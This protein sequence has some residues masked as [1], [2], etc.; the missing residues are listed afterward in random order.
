MTKQPSL[1]ALS[2]RY[3]IDLSKIP[4]H[5]AI[6]MDGNGRWAKKRRLP[7]IMGHRKGADRVR[8]IV[9]ACGELGVKNLTL[10]AFSEENWQRPKHE[11]S[12]IMTLINTY[13]RKEK[14]ELRQNKVKLQSIGSIEKLP[15]SCQ[16]MLAEVEDYLADGSGLTL[17]L[18]LSYGGRADLARTFRRLARKVLDNQLSPDDI[19]EQLLSVNIDEGKLDDVDLMIRTS[20]EIRI[21]NFLLWHLAYAELYFTKTQWPDFGIENLYEALREFQSRHRRFGAVV[22]DEGEVVDTKLSPLDDSL[23]LSNEL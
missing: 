5:V 23:C 1:E 9:R 20:G 22:S 16:Q 17:T 10:F 14:E 13:L 3:D 7:R 6:I 12:A 8:E 18:A 19:N 2:Q 4:N 15:T 11:V 21:S